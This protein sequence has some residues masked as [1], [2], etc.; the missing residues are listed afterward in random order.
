MTFQELLS[1][2]RD[3]GCEEER[4]AEAEYLE[5][6]VSKDKIQCYEAAL[7]AFF[8]PPFKPAGQSPSQE[9]NLY[10]NPYG[11][12]QQGQT[13]YLK[14]SEDSVTTLAFLWPWGNGTLVTLKVF[15]K[16]PS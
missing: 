9:A 8:G 3:L 13:M 16:K 4:S 1:E 12:I 6:V 11:G 10:A 2:I 15:R 5:I 14:K 7:N